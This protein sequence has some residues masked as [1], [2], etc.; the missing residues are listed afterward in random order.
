[1]YFKTKNEKLGINA[2]DGFLTFKD[3]TGTLRT[4]R[5]QSLEN[6]ERFYQLWQAAISISGDE[7]FGNSWV[8]NS[9]FRQLMTE[10]MQAIGIDRPELLSP[11]IMSQLLISY[12]DPESGEGDS[13]GLIFSF[14]HTFPKSPTSRNLT[15]NL[16][17]SLRE[18]LI[19]IVSL[20]QEFTP[21][22]PTEKI[23]HRVLLY[24]SLCG[25]YTAK[26][27]SNM[28]VILRKS[29]KFSLRNGQTK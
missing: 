8:F 4:L 5:E 7:D 27:I 28:L 18:L 14:H 19:L 13:V 6:F 1:M 17:G 29:K 12:T 23:A 26:S 10:A 15:K 9:D 2:S 20:L 22:T 21:R 24:L 3:A 16:S 25:T 11:T